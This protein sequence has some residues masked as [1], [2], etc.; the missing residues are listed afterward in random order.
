MLLKEAM[1]I[2]QSSAREKLD[3]ETF[4]KMNAW[5]E[6]MKMNPDALA[7]S[8]LWS[9][10]GGLCKHAYYLDIFS[11]DTADYL[12]DDNEDDKFSDIIAEQCA[13]V[14]ACKGINDKIDA[15]AARLVQNM[16]NALQSAMAEISAPN[17][18]SIQPPAP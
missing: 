12:R 6:G 18:Q 4:E 15:F 7:S 9:K 8:S 13:L 2:L 16:R 14:E 1:P 11:K 3:A 10:L 17:A 5:L